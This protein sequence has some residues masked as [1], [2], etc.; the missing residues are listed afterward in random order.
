MEEKKETVWPEKLETVLIDIPNKRFEVNGK[1]F[2]EAS[3][4]S[5]SFE[6]GVWYF[7]SYL[8]QRMKGD[9]GK[10]ETD[11]TKLTE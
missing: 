6:N 11:G 3:D 10:Y 7:V 1:S 4:V 5:I 2:A 8:P 9:W